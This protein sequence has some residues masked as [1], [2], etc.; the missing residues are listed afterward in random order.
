[1]QALAYPFETGPLEWADDKRTLFLYPQGPLP[2]ALAGTA[3]IYTPWKA[4]A[5]LY[6]RAGHTLLES[7]DA[8]KH[9]YD[10]V[11]I[12][13]PHQHDCARGI[14]AQGW[15]ALKSGGVMIAAA[16]NDAGGRRLGNILTPFIDGLQEISKYKCRIIHAHRI[17]NS[18]TLPQDWIDK[19]AWQKQ[20]NSGLWTRPG[21]FNWDRIDPGT[22]MLLNALPELSGTVADFGCGIGVIGQHLLKMNPGIQFLYAIDADH[23]AVLATQKNLAAFSKTQI[24][25]IWGDLTKKISPPKLDHVVMNPPFHHDKKEAVALGLACMR[26]AH[27]CLKKGGS[28]W[29]VANT[30]LPYEEFLSGLFTQHDQIARDKGFK[31]IRATT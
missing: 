5:D 19:A 15:A 4:D 23:R 8:L 30:H 27:S 26:Q 14:L 24:E 11:L 28:L 10:R 18:K 6:Q 9:D 2:A 29:M 16:A 20:P 22:H 1:M 25:I 3:D 13:V 17:N 21:L 7:A 12:R 31:V